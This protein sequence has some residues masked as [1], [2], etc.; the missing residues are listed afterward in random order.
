MV[1][2]S[3]TKTAT[4]RKRAPNKKTPVSS[5]RKNT[6]GFNKGFLLKILLV[7]MLLFCG[8]VIYLDAWVTDKFEGKR[9]SL[10][11]GISPVGSCGFAL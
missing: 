5:R 10:P 3:P 8:W 6:G 4:K 11:A 1:Q 7:G 9:W 2:K